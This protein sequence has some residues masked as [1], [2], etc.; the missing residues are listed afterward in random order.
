M[1][2]AYDNDEGGDLFDGGGRRDMAVIYSAV[3]EERNGG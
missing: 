3:G 2:T 1:M